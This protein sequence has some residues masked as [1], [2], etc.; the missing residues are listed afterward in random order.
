MFFYWRNRENVRIEKLQCLLFIVYLLICC[1][2]SSCCLRI[3]RCS[4]S[5]RERTGTVTI[6]VGSLA[7][8]ERQ[9]LHLADFVSL[10]PVVGGE[11]GARSSRKGLAE[12]CRS[13]VE[14]WWGCHSQGSLS[15]G[16]MTVSH[17]VCLAL[18]CN[19]EKY[20]PARHINQ[21]DSCC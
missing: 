11:R 14:W 8:T 17:Q 3:W 21:H 5:V 6:S 7:S 4:S 18:H 16:V 12:L 1:F 9:A 19:V 13:V 15:V 20:S 10:A 2:C